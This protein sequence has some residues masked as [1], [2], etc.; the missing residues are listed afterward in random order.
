MDTARLLQ[1][2]AEGDLTAWPDLA[3]DLERRADV[4]AAAQALGLLH[5][6]DH[7]V[8]A[9][10]W[11][12]RVTD[13]PELQNL[14]AQVLA[15]SEGWPLGKLRALTKDLLSGDFRLIREGAFLMGSYEDLFDERP[16]P[17]EIT[18]P[19]LLKTTP[20][21]QAEW[22]AL[23]GGE[24]PSFFQG[25]ALRPVE[26]VSWEDAARFCEALSAQTGGAYRLP[27][28]AE[29]EYACRAGTTDERYGDLDAIAWYWDNAH[30]STHPVAQK[31][32]NAWGLYDMLGNVEE[33]CL[34]WYGPYPAEDEPE[35]SKPLLSG[36]S[37]LRLFVQ[38][39]FTQPTLDPTGPA[40][41]DARVFRGGGWDSTS[42]FCIATSRQSDEPTSRAFNS[43]FRPAGLLG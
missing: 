7:V 32:P 16:H 35:P 22:L 2:L 10:Q 43:G 34:D 25:D 6:Q 9:A 4:Q 24:N 30:R 14:R 20:V 17:V 38:N 11:L 8:E 40:S 41:G 39:A 19:F 21:T 15:Q 12:A 33:W 18:R 5:A 29:W 3:R 37:K 26:Q 42:S 31:Q 1:L 36:S 27:T 13:T 28:E 23:M